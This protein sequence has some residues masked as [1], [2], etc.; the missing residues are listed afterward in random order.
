MAPLWEKIRRAH[1]GPLGTM[2]LRPFVKVLNR[3]EVTAL[4]LAKREWGIDDHVILLDI[5]AL[6][7]HDQT[8]EKHEAARPHR[9]GWGTESLQIRDKIE[10]LGKEIDALHGRQAELK[11]LIGSFDSTHVELRRAD[12]IVPRLF[13]SPAHVSDAQLSERIRPR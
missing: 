13:A 8:I 1:Q 5:D 11:G 9:D 12:K 4:M 6:K 2:E 3:A 7:R 10:A